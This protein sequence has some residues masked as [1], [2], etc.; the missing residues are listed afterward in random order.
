MTAPLQRSTYKTVKNDPIYLIFF[1]NVLN[2]LRTIQ[3]TL[4]KHDSLKKIEKSFL[5]TFKTLLKI[6]KKIEN[7]FTCN[8]SKRYEK[9]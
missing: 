1:L 2:F 6:K 4:L 9:I 3:K 8:K 7:L 5:E